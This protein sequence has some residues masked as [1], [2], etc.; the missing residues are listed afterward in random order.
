MMQD[1]VSLLHYWT[2]LPGVYLSQPFVFPDPSITVVTDASMEGLGFHTSSGQEG[3]GLWSETSSHL[4]IY[5]LELLSVLLALMTV[6]PSP[7]PQTLVLVRSNNT[8]VVSA[9]EEARLTPLLCFPSPSGCGLW[10][11]RE[12]GPWGRFTSRV[13]STPGRTPSPGL[14]HPD[15][16]D[17]GSCLVPVVVQADFHPPPRTANAHCRRLWR[18]LRWWERWSGLSVPGLEPVVGGCLLPSDSPVFRGV[19]RKIREFKGEALLLAPLWPLRPWF[20][21]VSLVPRPSYLFQL[22]TC[23]RW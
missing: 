12:G 23:L 10:S 6:R 21:P 11:Q 15:R 16:V 4:P 22:L 9:S 1:L 5:L 7:R 19:L 2:A 14:A 8:T 3:S 20:A 13:C 18:Q 17:V